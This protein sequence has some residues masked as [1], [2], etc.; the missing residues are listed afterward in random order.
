MSIGLIINNVNLDNLN[1]FV[2]AKL[3]YYKVTVFFSL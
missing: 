3:I 1:K 2:F